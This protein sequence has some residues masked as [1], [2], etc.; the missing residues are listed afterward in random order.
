VDGADRI[1]LQ[2]PK[3]LKADLADW[4]RDVNRGKA[5]STEEMTFT[6]SIHHDVLRPDAATLARRVR[7]RTGGCASANY[8]KR[9]SLDEDHVRLIMDRLVALEPMVGSTDARAPFRLT[10]S[11]ECDDW[12]ARSER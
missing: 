8:A 4:L 5:P 3:S 12:D 6:G 1:R 9:F 2:S 7:A 11:K 10:S